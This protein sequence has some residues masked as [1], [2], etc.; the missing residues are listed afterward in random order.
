ML[1]SNQDLILLIVAVA[2]I[3]I[4]FGIVF[5]FAILYYSKRKRKLQEEKEQ[6]IREF[7]KQT[8]QSQLEIQEQTFN[9]ISQEIHD[10]VGQILSLAKVQLNIAEQQID[11]VP[12]ILNDSKENIS[13]AMNDL[14]DIAKSLSTDRIEQLDLIQAIQQE[15]DRINKTRAIHCSINIEGIQ[16]KMDS[17]E[18]LIIFRIIQETLNNV[19]KHSGASQ[20]TI[21]ICFETEK[22]QINII[23]N[24]Y[25][26]DTELMKQKGLGLQ[27]IIRRTKLIGGEATIESAIEKGTTIYLTVPY[28]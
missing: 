8:L 9:A 12:Q 11:N 5:L 7:E 4:A 1:Q 18:K 21:R 23:D 19:L 10:N 20:V 14:R 25:G 15:A 28:A 3:L 6:L 2:L 27:N 22:M 17:N 16:Q 26:F 13:R 24:G